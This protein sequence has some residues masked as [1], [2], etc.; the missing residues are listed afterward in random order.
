MCT[1]NLGGGKK[2]N[3]IESNRI[4]NELGQNSVDS[5]LIR[6]LNK[7]KSW[8]SDLIH[9]IRLIKL[10]NES[11]RIQICLLFVYPNN[12]RIHNKSN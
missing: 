3:R 4:L 11:N 9:L 1:Y 2:N 6:L 7:L 12:K 10:I 8:D 5:D